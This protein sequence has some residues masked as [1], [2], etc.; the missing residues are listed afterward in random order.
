MPTISILAF[1]D[2]Q[3][4]LWPWDCL[5]L[6]RPTWSS[7]KIP[8]LDLIEGHYP[9]IGIHM[10]VSALH[11]AWKYIYSIQIVVLMQICLYRAIEKKCSKHQILKGETG[12]QAI[13]LICQRF[14]NFQPIILK[15]SANASFNKAI[16]MA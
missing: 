2:F 14:F 13:K 6:K 8:R 1:L 10:V 16:W 9:L 15:F 12:K 3:A 5:C 11:S 4:F 7:K